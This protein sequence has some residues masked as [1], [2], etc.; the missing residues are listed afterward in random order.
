MLLVF[1]YRV[2]VWVV[3]GRL[4]LLSDLQI[5]VHGPHIGALEHQEVR[6]LAFSGGGFKD[7]PRRPQLL[8][9]EGAEGLGRLGG[10]LLGHTDDL[11]RHVTRDALAGL[12]HGLRLGHGVAQV[13]H[14][15]QH[16]RPGLR[17]GLPRAVDG[18]S[19]GRHGGGGGGGLSLG[20]SFFLLLEPIRLRVAWWGRGRGLCGDVHA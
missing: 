3:E 1:A 13:L 12:Q 6:V 19:R 15:A 5:L 8:G 11:E 18:G 9:F 7:C 16:G 14:H 4:D 20:R 17:E 2:G 10:V